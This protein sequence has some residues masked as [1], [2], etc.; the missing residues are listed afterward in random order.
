M[1][2]VTP[3]VRSRMMGR[4]RGKDTK[5]ELAVRQLTHGLG[6]RF[7]LHVRH[8]PGRPDMV[9]PRH[10][11]VIFVHGCFW[12]R[13]DCAFATTPKTRPEFWEAKF[14]GNVERDQRNRKALIELGWK[15]L[16][17]WECELNDEPRLRRK[18][19]S[20]FGIAASR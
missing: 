17:I 7:R 12:H 14:R 13:H 4:I 20:A 10:R 16:E 5:A 19:R 3:E 15:V 6:L 18:L 8:L 2:I 9:L 1:D 11:T